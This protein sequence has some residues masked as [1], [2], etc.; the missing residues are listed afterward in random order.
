PRMTPHILNIKERYVVTDLEVAS[1]FKSSFSWRLYEYLKAHYGYF[2]RVLDKNEILRL[3][4]VKEIKTY[5][6]NIGD[7]K[8]RVLDV[9]INEINKFTELYVWYKEKKKGRSIVG[10]E[11]YWNKGKV[12]HKATQK[13]IDYIQSVISSVKDNMFTYM[14][15]DNEN[16]RQRAFET[17]EKVKS[18]EIH[19]TDPVN[20]SSERADNI[21][22]ELEFDL[23]VLNSL[24]EKDKKKRDTS[25][26]YN[27][28]EDK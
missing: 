13:Q 11:V 24:V 9:A 23:G 7:F 15:L 6:K 19:I 4:N 8:R 5:Q 17:I 10:F 26:Y 25:I 2:C 20:I 22:T 21:I 12:V 14:N 3:F 18:Q 1:Q 27:W 28:L 16:G